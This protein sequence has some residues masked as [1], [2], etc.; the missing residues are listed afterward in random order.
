[1]ATRSNIATKLS[2]AEIAWLDDI[3]ARFQTSG[4]SET[5][6]QLVRNAAQPAPRAPRKVPNVQN[7]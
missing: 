2:P 3:G 4:R 5:L 7:G 1:M 6:R